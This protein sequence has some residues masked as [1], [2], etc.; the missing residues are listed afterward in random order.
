MSACLSWILPQASSSSSTEAPAS[1]PPGACLFKA[2]DGSKLGEA[3]KAHMPDD[4]LLQFGPKGSYR[5]EHVLEFLSWLLSK[6][7][8]PDEYYMVVLD[9]FAPHLD[10]AVQ[11]LIAA[12]G[13]AHRFMIGGGLT[14][15]AAVCD[16]T[17]HHPLQQ[18][19]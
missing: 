2:A 16:V 12:G 4:I 13:N 10:P 7:C 9:W 17:A 5:L 11:E 14:D 6:L 15:K 18:N 1:A 8:Q 3:M 19:F